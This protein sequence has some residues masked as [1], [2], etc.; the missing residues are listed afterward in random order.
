MLWIINGLIYG[1]FTALYTLVNQKRHFNGYVLGVWRGFGIALLFAPW[2]MTMPLLKDWRSWLL[3]IAQGIFIGVYD[4]H[5]FFASAR[6]G[7]NNTSRLLVL[8]VLLTTI[9]WWGITP[10]KFL[11]LFEDANVFITLMLCIIGFC[12]CYWYML[13][14]NVNRQ[15]F[16]YMLPAIFALAFMS[17]A[18]KEISVIND[19][20]WHGIIYYLTVATSISGV[21]NLL[22]LV[23]T[24]ARQQAWREMIFAPPVIQTG[25]YIVGFSTVLIIAKTLALRIS[26]NPG[27]VVALLLTAPIFVYVLSPQYKK[28]EQ[29]S[30]KAGWAM[31]FFLSLIMLL[32]SSN[33]G[34]ND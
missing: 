10:Q 30:E 3:L 34:I 33:I 26:P 15:A 31:L 11:Q 6:F 20:V 21:Y 4:S 7:A 22:L 25:L 32:V 24:K 8:S 2:L 17:V 29:L 5:I 27:Y 18:T 1:F 14:S 23:K 9:L 16:I 28:R 13:Q 12:I 19:N